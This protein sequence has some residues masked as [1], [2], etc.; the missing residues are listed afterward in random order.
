MASI[1][2]INS[3]SKKIGSKLASIGTLQPR[4]DSEDELMEEMTERQKFLDEGASN[5]EDRR[6][7]QTLLSMLSVDGGSNKRSNKRSRRK[8]R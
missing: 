2:L 3:L 8:R 7:A 6:A 1:M 4:I 5:A